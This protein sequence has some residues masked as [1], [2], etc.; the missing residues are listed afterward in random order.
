[1]NPLDLL[2]NLSPNGKLAATAGGT[3][4]VVGAG[5]LAIGGH[6]QLLLLLV[7]LVVIAIVAFVVFRLMVAWWQKRKSRPMEQSLAGNAGAAPQQVSGAKKL[8]DLDSLRRVFASGVEKFRAAG[9]DMYSL[10]WYALVGQPGSGKTEAIRHSAIGFP[11]GLQDQLQGAG[12]TI[13]MNWWFTNH[14]I[15]LDTAGRLMFEEVVPGT[16]SEWQEF[17][18]LLRTHRPNCPINGMLLVIPA[19]SL[20]K[21]SSEVIARS[22]GKIAQQLDMIQRTL[23]VRF[24]VFVLITKSDYLTGFSQFF[25]DLTD[26]QL[27]HQIMGWSNP[28][29]LDD[30]FNMDAVEA[31]LR[32]VHDRLVERRQRL[33][34]DPVNT[35]D[36]SHNRMDQVDALF[37]FPEALMKIAP[38]LRQYLETIFVAGEWSAKPLFLR[39][40]YF[41][42][43]MSEG[44]ALDADLAQALGV[45]IDA[46]PASGVWRRDRAYF[47]RDLF[48]Q[49]V[50]KE[51][52][53]VTRAGNAMR[54]QR[55]RKMAVLAAGFAAVILLLGSTFYAFFELKNSIGTPRQY[56]QA[57]EKVFTSSS[58]QFMA[59]IVPKNNSIGAP[60]YIYQGHTNKILGHSLAS[61]YQQGFDLVSKPISV[62]WIFTPVSFF[63]G[64]VNQ[65][66]RAAFLKIYNQEVLDPVIGAAQARLAAAPIANQSTSLQALNARTSALLEFLALARISYQS[67]SAAAAS[68]A[69]SLKHFDSLMAYILPADEF[70]AYQSYQGDSTDKILSQLYNSPKQW[71]PAPLQLIQ[72]VD[73]AQA[74]QHGM[75]S[76]LAGWNREVG[77]G[78][79]ALQRLVALKSALQ[80]YQSLEAAL[81]H[82]AVRYQTGNNTIAGNAAYQKVHDLLLQLGTSAQQ[83]KLNMSALGSHATFYAAYLADAQALLHRRQEILNRLKQETAWLDTAGKSANSKAGPAGNIISTVLLGGPA[84]PKNIL[85]KSMAAL[86]AAR[87]ALLRDIA[88]EKSPFGSSSQAQITTLDQEFL[89]RAG[90]NR[91]VSLRQGMY[92]AVSHLISTPA[93][94]T[95]AM[96]AKAFLNTFNQEAQQAMAVISQASG[97]LK[98]AGPQASNA[99]N[100]ATAEA[101]VKAL[102]ALEAYR[103]SRMINTSVAHAPADASAIEQTI[104]KQVAAGHLS[105]I[106]K[107]MI[108]FTAHAG[109]PFDPHFNPLGAGQLL[110]GWYDM[111]NLLQQ[112]S[113][114]SAN[115]MHILGVRDL[116]ARYRAASKAYNVYRRAYFQYWLSSLSDGLSVQIPG[117]AWKSYL[118]QLQGVQVDQLFLALQSYGNR[119]ARALEAV[120]PPAGMADQITAA[121]ADIQAGINLLNVQLFARSTRHR[122]TRWMQLSGNPDTARNQLLSDTPITL[123]HRYILNNTSNSNF[124][125]DYV[126][127]LTLA[128]LQTLAQR[129]QQQ[130]NAI[131]T[132]VQAKEFF[133]LFIP[134]RVNQPFEHEWSPADITALSKHFSALP[135]GT[136]A[137]DQI[138]TPDSQVNRQLRILQ[139]NV[140][141]WHFGYSRPTVAALRKILAAIVGITGENPLTCKLQI[142]QAIKQNQTDNTVQIIWPFLTV[143]NAGSR[144]GTASFRSLAGDDL[145]KIVIPEKPGQS[146]KLNFYETDPAVAGTKPS[147]SLVFNGPWAA[148]KLLVRYNGTTKDGKTWLVHIHTLDQFKKVRTMALEMV[149]SRPLPPLSQW[150]KVKK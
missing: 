76:V 105:E 22:A 52:G 8:A 15:I 102:H 113:A 143:N 56:W 87:N 94:V 63:S 101:A 39:G 23:G 54:Q 126:K 53:L 73:F 69:E 77:T 90:A 129:S 67:G 36:P 81:V 24:P 4:G 17:L 139:G 130:A 9:K 117:N 41:T 61:F 134:A 123:Y 72:S 147:H 99:Y 96:E 7:L 68:R 137:P 26:P 83:I 145:G 35:E 38:R 133:P 124:A 100:Q 16:T 111:G 49:K 14:A 51:R 10:P 97:T 141:Y 104:A 64:T 75:T 84:V 121:K 110:G 131:L 82:W 46:L 30:P 125:S 71:P 44:K 79:Q 12:G 78:N 140:S 108:L 88:D 62:P 120:P 127:S 34:A 70:K 11:P 149:F 13:N 19:D 48:L 47:L 25:D 21:D 115:S 107:P 60:E 93:D 146:L 85:R 40:I 150:P 106:V 1:M 58:P 32:Q 103:L 28:A 3:A 92:A 6:W 65:R 95:S 132:S 142:T 148:L 42:S 112:A 98:S 31:H 86:A 135:S 122:L 114:N 138:L 29:A 43:S 59:I 66:Q 33:L 5:A 20:L 119:V 37:A 136:A 18:K 55:R 144:L 74:V 116:L 80:K 91:Q 2:G 50:F 89:A 118:Q 128:G 57:A 109:K 27:Q 45:S